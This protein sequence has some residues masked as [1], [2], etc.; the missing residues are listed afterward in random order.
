MFL[1]LKSCVACVI[2]TEKLNRFN[3]R[4][5]LAPAFAFDREKKNLCK[6]VHNTDSEAKA[7]SK[8]VNNP[9]HLWLD[10]NKQTT[11]IH[12][13]RKFYKRTFALLLCYLPEMEATMLKVFFSICSTKRCTILTR[14]VWTK[15]RGYL[16][17]NMDHFELCTVSISPAL[18]QCQPRTENQ[19]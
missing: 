3:I 9:F 5:L 1:I 4:L 11:K 17:L 7:L 15:G 12:K 16:P 14:M 6:Q 2:R 13:K 18:T 8:V 10:F 19:K